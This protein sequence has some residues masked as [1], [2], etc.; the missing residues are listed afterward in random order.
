VSHVPTSAFSIAH[1]STKSATS[2][3]G[4][5]R[6]LD[7][8]DRRAAADRALVL[9]PHGDRVIETEIK[10]VFLCLF[11]FIVLA[12]VS[13]GHAVLPAFI[14]GLVMSR[15]YQQHREEQKRTRVVAFAFLTPFFIKGGPNVSL[16]V[17]VAN[18]GLLAALLAAQMV[19]KVASWRRRSMRIARPPLH[20]WPS[21]PCDE[22]Y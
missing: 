19:P 2:G 21:A 20:R 8:V 11:V 17:V 18:L 6:R 16:G 3:S 7:C 22:F 12:D 14:L 9:W 5:P 13:N 4:L 1:V 15:H 10:L